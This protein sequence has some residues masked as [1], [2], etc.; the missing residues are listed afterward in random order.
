MQKEKP[1]LSAA[2]VAGFRAIEAEKPDSDRIVYDPYAH[3]FT[4]GGLGWPISRWIIK[5]GLYERMAPGA[6]AYILLRERYIDDFLKGELGPGLKQV[7]I[8]GAGYDTRAYRIPGIEKTRVFE[9]DE[10]A[11]QNRK[12][13]LLVKVV[14]PVPTF[15]SFVPVNFNTE[16]LGA[17]L[18]GAGYDENAKTAFIWQGVT[19]F[20]TS[21][22]VD[23][24]LAFIAGKSGEGSTV[25]FDY[26]YNETLRD[27]TR[28]DVKMLKRSARI[29]GEAYLFG[30]DKGCVSDF[31]HHRGFAEV[32]D[33][34]LE[35]LKQKY[36]TGANAGRSVPSGIAIASAKVKK[37][38]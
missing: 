16:S 31:L 29:S 10:R 19:Y 30:I 24:T 13:E 6:N 2:G 4:P 9:V 25:V 26:M 14:N 34:T 8:L 18:H 33:K 17:A 7:V 15:V 22:G 36:F 37:T 3:I 20:L 27:E 23:K 5:S 21:E 32:Q 38:R 28:K 1:S 11:T 12:K 35:D